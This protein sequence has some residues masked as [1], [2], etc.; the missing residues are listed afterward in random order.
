M[1]ADQ[2][3]RNFARWDQSRNFGLSASHNM[4]L[5]NKDLRGEGIFG[6]IVYSMGYEEAKDHGL[7][8]PIKVIWTKVKTDFDPCEGTDDVMK[9]KLGIW[10]ND[11]R[12]DLIAN[13]ARVDEDGKPWGDDT[14]VLIT[15]STIEH[16]VHLKKRLPE[17]TLVY[18]ENGM[19]DRDRSMYVR[20]GFLPANEP[21]M[22]AERRQVL[23]RRFEKGMLKKAICTTVWNVGV[24]FQDLAVLVR[25][26]GGGSPVND[27]QIP[28]RTSRLGT[29]KDK[30]IGIVRDYTDQ[31]NS[32]FQRKAAGRSRNYAAKGWE[33]V[34]PGKQKTLLG[35]EMDW[36]D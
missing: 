16:A 6:P 11:Y 13:D 36:D 24:D 31:F 14:Q 7:V 12:N 30:K 17:F 19:S 4:R 18:A 32:G 25:A 2:A 20:Y 22:T 27:T 23:A 29:N 26:D 10:T 8:V 35:A 33:Q 21:R 1:V 34:Y 5:D 9:N 15:C 3:A 28:G